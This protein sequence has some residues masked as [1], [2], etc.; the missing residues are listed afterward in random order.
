M[1]VNKKDPN[2]L[3]EGIMNYKNGF[4]TITYS[5]PVK[6]LTSSSRVFRYDTVEQYKMSFLQSIQNELY[7]NLTTNVT[8]DPYGNTF[9][10]VSLNI[11]PPSTKFTHVENDFF[12]VDGVK[13][14]EDELIES[15][16]TSHP[17]KF[18]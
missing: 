13:F 11:A 6:K 17:E 4:N 8:R 12:I 2:Y 14:T 7:D 18:L 1:S 15:V 9:V 5:E 16:R 3:Y 10:D